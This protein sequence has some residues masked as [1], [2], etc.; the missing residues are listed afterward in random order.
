MRVSTP[1]FYF[2]SRPSFAA[3]A[4]VELASNPSILKSAFPRHQHNPSAYS[5]LAKQ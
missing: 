5:P 2:S 4:Q 1:L 3:I